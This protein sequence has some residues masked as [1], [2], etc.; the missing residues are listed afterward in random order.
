MS[1]KNDKAKY[2]LTIEIYENGN[3]KMIPSEKMNPEFILDILQ[4]HARQV[5]RNLIYSSIMVELNQKQNK[6]V[7]PH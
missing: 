2:F 7:L 3:S 4:S 6:I 1:K 5:E